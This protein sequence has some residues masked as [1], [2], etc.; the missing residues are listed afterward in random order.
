MRQNNEIELILELIRRRCSMY[1]DIVRIMPDKGFGFIKG[2]DRVEY[3][4]HKSDFAGFFDDLVYDIGSNKRVV[5]S[6]DI[7]PS[8]KGP[9]AGNVNRLLPHSITQEPT[10]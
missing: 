7:V 8:E 1:G 3:F 4:F 9:R 10:D 2:E 5:V 6:F